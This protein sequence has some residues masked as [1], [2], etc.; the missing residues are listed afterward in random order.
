MGGFDGDCAF[1]FNDFFG[2]FDGVD[3]VGLGKGSFG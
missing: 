3:V 2:K 1:L